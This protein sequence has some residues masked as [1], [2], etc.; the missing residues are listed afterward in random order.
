ML[1][2]NDQML[3]IYRTTT[4]SLSE[5]F[6]VF[7]TNAERIQN[8]QLN[9]TKELLSSHSATEQEMKTARSFNEMVD[10]QSKLAREQWTKTLSSLGEI[11]ASGSLGQM[12]VIRQAQSHALQIID[13]LSETLD[14]IPPE[15]APFL[16]PVK[17][18]VGAARA[19][20]A[21]N[22]RATEE[23]ALMAASKIE[24]AEGDAK[25]SAGRR[26]AA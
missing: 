3:G 8:S 23:A 11:Y 17:M 20:C 9:A 6:N 15:T 25:K 24:V 5:L 13:G 2:P 22:I 19:G 12:E 21:A 18:M 26:H 14:G 7:L 4:Q 10:I 1:Q 16:S